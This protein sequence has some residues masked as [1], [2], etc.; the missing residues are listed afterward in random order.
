MSLLPQLGLKGRGRPYNPCV[1]SA[2]RAQSPPT[3]LPA[4]EPCALGPPGPVLGPHTG[5][6]S[7]PGPSAPGRLISEAGEVPVGSSC[8]CWVKLEVP[9]LP[10]TNSSLG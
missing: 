5:H 7:G 8:S 2:S 9:A 1:E 3:G 10:E 6:P 4:L